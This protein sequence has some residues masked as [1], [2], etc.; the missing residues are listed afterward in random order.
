MTPP[1]TF[2][3]LRSIPPTSQSAGG[4]A[5][6]A[7]IGIHPLELPGYVNRTYMT[8]RSSQHQLEMSSLH[9][10]AEYPDRMVQRVLGD[11]LRVLLPRARV[12]DPPWPVG[13]HADFSLAVQFREL[14]K[15]PENDVLL[16]ASWTITDM[17]EPSAMQSHRIVLAEPVEG[18]GYDDL[19][20]AHSRALEELCRSIASTLEPVIANSSGSG[21]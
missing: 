20:A 3:T 13:L 10:W 15:T 11:N 7:T 1:V 17:A 21:K 14:I 8:T 6:V 19:A 18:S 16:S 2:Y 9:R 5:F 4:G 12:V